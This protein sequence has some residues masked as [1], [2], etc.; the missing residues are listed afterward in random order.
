MKQ[1]KKLTAIILSA[2][3]VTCA[4]PFAVSAEQTAAA[5]TQDK[6]ILGDANGDGIVDVIDATIA[7]TDSSGNVLS[8]IKSQLSGTV[9]VLYYTD[10]S[11]SLTSCKAVTGGT[12]SGSF[13]SFGY[14]EGGTLSG[15]TSSTLSQTSAGG[16][17]FNPGGPGGRW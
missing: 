14:A 3:L 10:R 7:V 9:G 2:L 13:D 4:A 5:E 1:G 6:L 17:G 11:S 8:I 12:Y 15:G 16:G